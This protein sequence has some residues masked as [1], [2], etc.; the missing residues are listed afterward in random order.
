MRQS[1]GQSEVSARNL[2]D[3]AKQCVE[4]SEPAFNEDEVLEILID[5]ARETMERA[6]T[7]REK[8]FWFRRMQRF[9]ADRSPAQVARMEAER[10]LS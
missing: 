9:I 5:L 7:P 1:V 2:A 6:T 4:A 8:R 10:G 3:I